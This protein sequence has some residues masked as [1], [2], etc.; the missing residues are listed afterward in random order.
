MGGVNIYCG[1]FIG[2]DKSGTPFEA[3]LADL[4]DQAGSGVQDVIRRINEALETAQDHVLVQ[5]DDASVL[6]DDLAAQVDR[7]EPDQ[8]DDR[9][10]T[11]AEDLL[12]ACHTAVA[13]GQPIALVW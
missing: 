4:A 1:T 2:E 9:R 10:K 11:C 6:I 3:V 12:K 13:E 8:P 7:Y 5:P